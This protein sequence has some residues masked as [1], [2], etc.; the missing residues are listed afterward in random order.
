MEI[1]GGIAF[2]KNCGIINQERI[3]MLKKCKHC[4]CEL[5]E[6]NA[7]KSGRNGKHFRN[8][9]KP[10]RSKIVVKQREIYGDRLR[11]YANAYA[12][13]IGKVKQYECLVCKIPCLKKYEHAFCSD[14]CR[15]WSYVKVENGCWVFQGG[16]DRAGYGKFGSGRAHRA[17]YK[18]FK[19]DVPDNLLVCHTCDNP[20]CVNPDHLW[21][22]TNSDNQKDSIKKGR[23]ILLKK[24]REKGPDADLQPSNS[25]TN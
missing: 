13:K 15:L 16:R 25:P 5:T 4:G 21:L 20:P 3:Y 19:G 14:K 23:R 17:S 2:L 24:L 18:I 9:C 8:E 6:T 11:A 7:A 1:I 10:C 12:R 22:G